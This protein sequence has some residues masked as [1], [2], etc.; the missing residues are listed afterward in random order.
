MINKSHDGYLVI[1]HRA[2]PGIPE[3][4]ARSIGL[5]PK[6]CGEGKIME[7]ATL[8]CSHCR[9]VAI[10]NPL[11]TRERHYCPK[12]NHYIC[13]GCAVVMAMPNYMHLS[14]EERKDKAFNCAKKEFVLGS[15]HKL[16]ND[17]P[18]AVEK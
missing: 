5:D 9:G 18:K 8:S 13:D 14:F 2:S 3:A 6:L 11:R 4:I 10:M 17:Q 15:P 1:D 7:A 16:L 12:C